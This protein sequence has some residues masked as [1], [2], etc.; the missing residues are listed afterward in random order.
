MFENSIVM[1]P[2]GASV[3]R[4]VREQSRRAPQSLQFALHQ[5]LVNVKFAVFSVLAGFLRLLINIEILI[6][7]PYAERCINMWQQGLGML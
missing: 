1:S 6:A 4:S 7:L 3:S 2:A 5:V